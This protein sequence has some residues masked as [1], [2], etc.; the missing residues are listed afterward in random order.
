MFVRQKKNK[1]GSMSVIV[2]R[3]EKGRYK[4]VKTM[5]SSSDPQEIESL[6]RQGKE[7]IRRQ[8]GMSDMFAD[9]EGRIR[10]KGEVERFFA[11]IENVL[12]NGDS[13]IIE[14]IFDSIGFA[15]IKDDVF[16]KL[17]IARLSFPSSKAATVEYLKNHF[18]EDVDLSKIYRYL[19]KWT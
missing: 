10:E 19:D 15:E 3:K 7:W 13:L 6:S 2:V 12:V 5:G 16:K 9:A 17:V 8:T 1:S 14:R 11:S 18:D 4:L